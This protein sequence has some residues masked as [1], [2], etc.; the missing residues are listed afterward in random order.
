M[1]DT[2]QPLEHVSP[3]EQRQISPLPTGQLPRAK[4]MTHIRWWVIFLCFLATTINYMDRT[5]IAVSAPYIGHDL[6]IN[7][8]LMGLVLSAFF[9]TYAVFQLPSG[10]FVDRFGP[11]ISYTFACAWW[12]VMTGLVSIVNGFAVLLGLRL[13]LGAGEAPAYPTD[14]KVASEWFPVRERGIA[15]AIFDIGSKTGTAFALPLV[16]YLIAAYGWRAAFVATAILGL[17][18]TA[19]WVWYYRNLRDHPHVSAAEREYII[20]GSARE[21]EQPG[22][23]LTGE[24]TTLAAMQARPRQAISWGSLFRYRKIWGMMIGFF[25]FNFVIY[26]Y[27]TW[28]PDYLVTARHF[29][30]LK[31]GTY[32]MI[33]PLSGVVGELLGGFVSDRLVC[34]GVSLT[35]ARKIPIVIGML[36]ASVIAIAVVVPSAGAAL[37][38]LSLCYAALVFA[39]PSIWSL[40]ADVAPRAG[41]VASIGGIQN[42]A[43]NLAGIVLPIYTGVV[44]QLTNGSFVIPLVTAGAFA[45]IGALTYLFVVGR[46]EPLQA[47]V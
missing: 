38:L 5:N 6:H 18:W 43:S 29:S 17:I 9:W 20:Q 33:P 1:A 46:V 32:G 27:I 42:F 35:V 23:A 47:K 8:A 26:F 16:T 13:L 24:E 36:L 45:V 25:A 15:T 7:S 34:S 41:L 19:I 31:L 21:V 14:A 3:E 11:R 30:L 37:A 39:A 22:D 44:L 4:R 10:W 12:S 40:P 28:F 2:S